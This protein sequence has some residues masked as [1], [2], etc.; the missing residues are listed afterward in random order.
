[1]IEYD[2][3]DPARPMVVT[4]SQQVTN[5]FVKYKE[6]VLPNQKNG[7]Y[8]HGRERYDAVL[9]VF[10]QQK[11]SPSNDTVWAALKAASQEPNPESITSNTQWSIAYNNTDLTAEIIIRRHWADMTRYSLTAG[12]AK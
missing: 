5:F 12:A 2:C 3:D 8:G 10:D 1:M 6:N 7:I 11:D 9:E 4:P